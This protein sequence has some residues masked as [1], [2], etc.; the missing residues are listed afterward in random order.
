VRTCC[1]KCAAKAKANPA[2]TRAKV[3]ALA[4]AE[5]GKSDKE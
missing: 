1:P 3:V 5:G 2:A 4:G